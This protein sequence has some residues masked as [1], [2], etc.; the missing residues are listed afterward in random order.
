MGGSRSE[1]GPVAA[2][3][4]GLAVVEVWPSRGSSVAHVFRTKRE[5][6]RYARRAQVADIDGVATLD[7]IWWDDCNRSLASLIGPPERW[8]IHDHR[9]VS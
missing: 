1:P 5:A 2:L 9:E 3:F 6:E 4:N 8:T 7:W